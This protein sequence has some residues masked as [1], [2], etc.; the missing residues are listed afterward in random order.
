[1]RFSRHI[2]FFLFLF[3]LAI[4]N[5]SHA[6]YIKYRD[7]NG[8]HFATPTYSTLIYI[9]E[10]DDLA[11][12]EVL[13]N[14]F[15]LFRS[16]TSGPFP[17]TNF[18]CGGS[19][20]NID[21]SSDFD[22]LTDCNYWIFTPTPFRFIAESFVDNG[23]SS[24]DITIPQISLIG[25]SIIDID[26]N[27]TFNDLGAT[28]SDDTDGDITNN[29]ITNNSVD[30]SIVGS[31]FVTYDVIDLAGNSADQVTRTVNIISFNSSLPFINL[32]GS[33]SITLTKGDIFSDFGATAS[34][35]VD[36][37]ITN[38]ILI[39][40]SVDTDTVGIY[41]LFYNVFDSDGNAA[42]QV[43]RTIT[44]NAVPSENVTS[45][46]LEKT[47]IT[48]A[49]TAFSIFGFTTGMTFRFDS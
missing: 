24:V 28:A 40:G 33:S 30:V 12:V 7:D 20:R 41:T 27:S 45:E 39:S 38:Q 25:P 26:Q 1:M 6:E 18:N 19:I 44:V 3:S 4:F 22:S 8:W 34:D 23:D 13:P 48:I 35:D 29:I 31:Y 49:L 37:D 15:D 10:L 43:S 17:F 9:S 47:I 21:D 36:G 16:I 46:Q 5:K 32:L 11:I 42:N 2:L 14:S